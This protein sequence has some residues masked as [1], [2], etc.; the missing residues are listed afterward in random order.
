MLLRRHASLRARC[1]RAIESRSFPLPLDPLEMNGFRFFF[2]LSPT[3]DYH[4]RVKHTTERSCTLVFWATV[5]ATLGAPFCLGA[6]AFPGEF[7]RPPR[8]PDSGKVRSIQGQLRRKLV[9]LLSSWK[10]SA[11]LPFNFARLIEISRVLS[12]LIF[13]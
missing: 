8:G 5:R 4:L 10:K 6:S 12:F 11:R 3:L 2:S 1:A 7:T 13:V 9:G